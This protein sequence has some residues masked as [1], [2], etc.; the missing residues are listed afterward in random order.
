M[1]T[2]KQ[3]AVRTGWSVDKVRR[4]INSGKLK[5]VDTSSGQRP[6]FEIAESDLER[7]LNGG[8][9]PARKQPA[10]AI[11]SMVPQVF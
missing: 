11:D 2:T 4:L 8:K 6:T 7:F 9:R 5:A 1:L 3:V 10:P